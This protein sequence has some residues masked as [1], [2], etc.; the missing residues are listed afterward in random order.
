MSWGLQAWGCQPSSK[1]ACVWPCALRAAAHH[2]GTR[3]SFSKLHKDYASSQASLFQASWLSAEMRACVITALSNQS[4]G[5]T[6]TLGFPRGRAGM[7]GAEPRLGRPPAPL[8]SRPLH[9]L[10][11]RARWGPRALCALLELWLLE[12]LPYFFLQMLSLNSPSEPLSP[13]PSAWLEIAPLE[14]IMCGLKR[15]FF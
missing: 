10:S 13:V 5:G 11:L 15:I 1:E 7:C 12:P 4:G 9:T 14:L 2:A 6:D 8:F 3:T